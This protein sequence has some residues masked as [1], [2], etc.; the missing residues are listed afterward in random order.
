MSDMNLSDIFFISINSLRA[1]MCHHTLF[2]I[3]FAIYY[4]EKI[5]KHIQFVY[6]TR[7]QFNDFKIIKQ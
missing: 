2:G 3:Y 6:P 1:S 7:K 5:N 4:T